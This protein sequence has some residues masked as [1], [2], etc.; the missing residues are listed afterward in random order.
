MEISPIRKI[1]YFTPMTTLILGASSDVAIALARRLAAAG[2]SLQLA[3][4]DLEHLAALKSDLEI[5]YGINVVTCFFDATDYLSHRA[6]YNSL[7]PKPDTAIVAFGFL[8]TGDVFLNE[9]ASQQVLA[10][11]YVG[12]VSILNIIGA[13][14]EIRKYGT[15]VGISSVAGDRGRMSNFVYGS[16]KAGFT[17]YL[18]GLRNRLVHSKV[19]VLTVKPGFIRTRMTEGLALPPVLTASA[20]EVAVRI[21][22]AIKKKNNVIYVLPVWRMIMWIIRNIPERIFKKLKL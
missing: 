10:V 12:A 16:A 9:V 18:S 15:V 2:H 22:A 8:G 14:F 17:V 5:R 20:D 11:N 7:E 4:R 1:E 3:A 13:D 19:H 6:F 21:L